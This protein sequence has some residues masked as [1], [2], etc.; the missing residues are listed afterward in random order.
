MLNLGRAVAVDDQLTIQPL[1]CPGAVSLSF[2]GVEDE[3]VEPEEEMFTWDDVL[4][5][6]WRIVAV[7]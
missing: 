4:N 5:G 7:A 6:D 1:L 2:G 3:D